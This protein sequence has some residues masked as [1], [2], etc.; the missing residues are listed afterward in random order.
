MTNGLTILVVDDV[1]TNLI[2]LKAIL[3]KEGFMVLTA[4]S[5]REART[6]A[7]SRPVNLVLLD[8]CMPDEDGLETCVQLKREPATESIPVIFISDLS[9]VNNKLRGFEAGAVDYITKPFEKAEVLARVRLHLRLSEGRRA[10]IAEHSARLRELS[11]AQQA[12]LA[13]PED[14]PEANF[15]VF[16]RPAGA[17]GGD[18]YDVIRLSEGI[19]GYLAADVS[20]HDLGTSLTTPAIKAVVNRFAGPLYTPVETVRA[21]NDIIRPVLPE[22]HYMTLIFAHLNRWRGRLT[23]VNAGHP[24]AIF[25]PAAGAPR[26]LEGEGDVVGIFDHVHFEPVELNVTRGDRL[27]LYT[28]GVLNAVGGGG[29]QNKIDELARRCH[30]AGNLPLAQAVAEIAAALNPVA[31][32]LHDDLLLLGVEI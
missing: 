17:A 29:R 28:D 2:L 26:A 13:R 6:L 19:F 3:R 31:P 22:G 12:I 5:G 16:Y 32:E 25:V 11:Q 20:G 27:F 18:F 21:L 30:T 9:D 1:N 10:L 14:F 15:A 7:A 4:S 8:I 23:L 24:P